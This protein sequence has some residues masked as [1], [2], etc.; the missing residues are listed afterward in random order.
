MCDP[1]GKAFTAFAAEQR[2][3]STS[4]VLCNVDAMFA[5]VHALSLGPAYL[6]A[7]QPTDS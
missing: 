7:Y 5:A 3:S 2:S 6:P 1:C 4:D